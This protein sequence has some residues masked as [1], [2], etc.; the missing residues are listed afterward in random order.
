MAVYFG[1]QTG[2]AEGFA[3]QV[4]KE[5]AAQGFDCRCQQQQCQLKE[6]ATR[7]RLV[8]VV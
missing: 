8:A 6:V 2:T 5:A 7:E 4:K 3:E 1:S